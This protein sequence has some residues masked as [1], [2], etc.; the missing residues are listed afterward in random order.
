M[1]TAIVLAGSRGGRPDPMA[2][3][4]GLSHKALLAV[5]GEPM[6]SRVI[7]A[8][9]GCPGID[10]IVVCA[11][12]AEN[13]LANCPG[14]EGVLGRP[15]SP[16]PSL[17]V[18][19]MLAE[20]GAPLLI[21]TA[22]H[23]LL[24]PEMLAH[25]L[26][27]A[28]AGADVAAGVATEAVVMAAFPDTR[29]TWLRFRDGRVSGCN[30]FLLRTPHAD[31]VL[32]FW[33]RVE[34][35]RKRPVR[36]ARLIGLRALFLYATGLGTLPAMLRVLGRRVGAKLA[37]VT[38]PFADAAIDVDKPGDLALVRRIVTERDRKR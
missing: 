14:T 11:D 28:P 18:A 21:T 4:A 25:L 33:R 10:R 6:L 24:T 1:T 17:S 5:G 8:V 37:V 27:H 34:E 20:F 19:A 22:D 15:Q 26:H 3:A 29:R 31:G 7:R 23:A 16:S 9:R 35:S 13:L 38:L 30:L 12:G 2:V 32:R 36:I